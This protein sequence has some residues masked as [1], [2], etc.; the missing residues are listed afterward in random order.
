MIQNTGL[1]NNELFTQIM[2]NIPSDMDIQTNPD[3]LL[4]RFAREYKQNVQDGEVN[5]DQ[6]SIDLMMKLVHEIIPE[7]FL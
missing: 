5:S 2:S 7:D 3:E 4:E 6:H 1:S